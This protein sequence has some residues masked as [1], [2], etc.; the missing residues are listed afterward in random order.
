MLVW[1]DWP[2]GP[3]LFGLYIMLIV[4]YVF[5]WGPS[6][7]GDRIY[8]E[9]IA[10]L[11]L[12][13]GYGST[14]LPDREGS[15]ATKAVSTCVLIAIISVLIIGN[16]RAY[17]M[18]TIPAYAAINAWNV[19][20]HK[21]LIGHFSSRRPP[22]PVDIYWIGLPDYLERVLPGPSCIDKMVNLHF[23]ERVVSRLTFPIYR[24]HTPDRELFAPSPFPYGPPSR[25]D[26]IIYDDGKRMEII[27]YDQAVEVL[28][29]LAPKLWPSP[30]LINLKKGG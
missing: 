1:K 21:L 16:V 8:Y 9:S 13:L 25:S 18:S 19:K 3:I 14:R 5:V 6:L 24:T 26:V 28:E 22:Y 20:A 23:G 15:A 2:R 11:C 17:R 27:T 29:R 7:E 12:F 4:P 30:D 10:A